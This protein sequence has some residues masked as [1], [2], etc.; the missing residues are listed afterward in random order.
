MGKT[1]FAFTPYHFSQLKQNLL[2]MRQKHEEF[3]TTPFSQNEILQ[4][5]VKQSDHQAV[6][7]AGRLYGTYLPYYITFNHLTAQTTCAVP[8]QVSLTQGRQWGFP[9]YANTIADDAPRDLVQAFVDYCETRVSIA[10]EYGLVHQT[11]DV[12]NELC[13]TPAQVA[14]LWPSVH[15]LAKDKQL[16]ELL[17]KRP[18]SLP[19]VPP[20]LREACAVTAT[21]ITMNTMLGTAPPQNWGV[22]VAPSGHFV[23]TGPMGNFKIHT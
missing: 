13:S 14:F 2:E 6:L 3:E 5:F 11:L 10:R 23:A 1:A 4:L 9:R 18:K 21:T 16:K 17:S 20:Q 22:C 7:E 12:L 15:A 8:F 19:A